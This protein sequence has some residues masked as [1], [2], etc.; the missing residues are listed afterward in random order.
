[1]HVAQHVLKYQHGTV[2]YDTTIYGL[3]YVSNSEVQLQRFTKSN[4]EESVEDKEFI[5][6]LLH[7]GSIIISWMRNK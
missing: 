1:M 4:W 3:R 5:R 6:I 7:F 2:D